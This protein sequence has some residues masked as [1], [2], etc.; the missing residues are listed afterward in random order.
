MASTSSS[1]PQPQ[2]S[3][4]SLFSFLVRG[5]GTVVRRYMPMSLFWRTFLLLS[6]MLGVGILGWVYTLRFLELEPRG[7][8][9]AQQIAS[10]VNLSRA[11][12]RY[13]DQVNRVALVKNIAE[14]EAVKLQP[15]EPDHR[16]SS[17]AA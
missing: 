5:L 16:P 11:A 2:A 7:V 17:P 13:T 1:Y 14:Q 6:L 10:L 12:L 8:Q 4:E 3:R 15:R 9:A